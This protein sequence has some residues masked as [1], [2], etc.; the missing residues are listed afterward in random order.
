MAINIPKHCR[1]SERHNPPPDAPGGGF[2]HRE[3]VN[4]LTNVQEFLSSFF[5][6]ARIIALI[7]SLIASGSIGQAFIN[8][9]NSGS[10]V[11]FLLFSLLFFCTSVVL[12]LSPV[13]T[14]VVH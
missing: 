6:A 10:S 9:V 12:V 1:L 8:R 2:L 5:K 7:P 3:R 4:V 11:F 13:G 14:L